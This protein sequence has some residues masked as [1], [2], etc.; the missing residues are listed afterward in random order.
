MIIGYI[1]NHSTLVEFHTKNNEVSKISTDLSKVRDTNYNLLILNSTDE[2]I[3][4]LDKTIEAEG[5]HCPVVT[6][7][8]VNLSLEILDSISAQ[9]LETISSKI[10]KSW[11]LKNNLNLIESLYNTTKHL[12]N[13]WLND[14]NAFF[15]EMWFLL[16]TNIGA[17]KIDIIFHD[18]KEPT[19][20]Q[21]EKGA[22]NQLIYAIVKGEKNQ[23]IFEAKEAQNN[24]MI[25]YKNEFNSAFQITDFSKEKQ[26][27]VI[28]SKLKLSPILILIKTAEFNSIQKSL[29][30]GLFNSIAQ[31]A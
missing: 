7:S 29:F 13:L 16:K 26:E 25:E 5:K 30:T 20:A 27:L 1:K 8:S 22:K 9:E 17:D 14:R 6:D 19:D 24:L 28:T 11:V 10:F 15:E 21:K 2:T 4:Q 18:L 23:Q 12:D 31:E 3:E